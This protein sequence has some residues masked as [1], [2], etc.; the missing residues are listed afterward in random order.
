EIGV[1][2]NIDARLGLSVAA[3][4]DGSGPSLE[5]Q[6]IAGSVDADAT[7]TETRDTQGTASAEDDTRTY[8]VDMS[9]NPDVSSDIWAVDL[10]LG[11][12][13]GMSMAVTQN[14]AGQI[15]EIAIVSTNEGAINGGVDL[16]GE[17]G[18]GGNG[19]FFTSHE[20]T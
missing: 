4:E 2:G 3:T 7:W 14:A 17:S 1:T 12:T 5:A 18:S 15:T 19:S 13:V 11:D 9:I 6:A 16:R 10:G 8:T 20:E